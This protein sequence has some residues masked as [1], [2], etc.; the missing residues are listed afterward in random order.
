MITDDYLMITDLIV[1][2][3]IWLH[4]LNLMAS[5]GGKYELIKTTSITIFSQREIYQKSQSL[6]RFLNFRKVQKFQGVDRTLKLK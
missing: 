5:G 2:L 6:Y 1:K 3:T 4:Q